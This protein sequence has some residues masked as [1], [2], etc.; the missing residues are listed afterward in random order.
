MSSEK[1]NK[2]EK[3]QHTVKRG[4]EQHEKAHQN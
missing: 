3:M 4:G 2:M 1:N